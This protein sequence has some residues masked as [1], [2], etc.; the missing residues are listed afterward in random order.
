MCGIGLGGSLTSQSNDLCYKPAFA[1]GFQSMHQC[2]VFVF[3]FRWQINQSLTY[4]FLR[5]YCIGFWR[6]EV[7]DS[8]QKFYFDIFWRMVTTSITGFPKSFLSPLLYETQVTEMNDL[9]VIKQKTK[10]DVL[11]I[12]K[13][14]W[15]FVFWPDCCLFPKISCQQR[16]ACLCCVKLNGAILESYCHHK[17]PR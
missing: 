3:F 9:R 1:H 10:D 5:G 6:L 13:F 11:L 14:E 4:S 12:G 8:T 7:G 17:V 16:S 15:N 2:F